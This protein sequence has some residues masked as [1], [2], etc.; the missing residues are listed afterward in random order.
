MRFSHEH[1]LLP[2]AITD[3]P[4]DESPYGVRGMA[5]NVSDWTSTVYKKRGPLIEG[6]RLKLSD[7]GNG[8]ERT[9]RVLLGGHW[10]SDPVG[11]R[12]SSR[13]DVPQ[14]ARINQFGIRLARSVH[15]G[16]LHSGGFGG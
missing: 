6:G 3:F 11:T 14:T 4:L 7:I 10:Y 1:D 9:A 15:Q 13:K 8:N 12:I 5:G 16:I 2:A